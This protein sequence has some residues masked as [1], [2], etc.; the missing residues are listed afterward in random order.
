VATAQGSCIA[1]GESDGKA[2]KGKG[3]R[4]IQLRHFG[5]FHYHEMS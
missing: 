4:S 5:I 2:E 1:P 3:G